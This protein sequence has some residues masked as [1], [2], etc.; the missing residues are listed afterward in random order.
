M[1]KEKIKF[2]NEI[3]TVLYLSKD[4]IYFGKR[5][6][7]V[8]V[9]DNLQEAIRV[10]PNTLKYTHKQNT[11]EYIGKLPEF[12]PDLEN[13]KLESFLVDQ[14]G[15]RIAIG[16]LKHTQQWVVSELDSGLQ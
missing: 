9:I 3:M 7:T 1:H 14:N 11:P 13:V 16:F 4:K 12:L 5:D 2:E 8:Y 15:K 6:G 10:E